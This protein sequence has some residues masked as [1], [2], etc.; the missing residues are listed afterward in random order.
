[1]F[2]RTL[3]NVAYYIYYIRILTEYVFQ[4]FFDLK[5][6]KKWCNFR[7]ISSV[8]INSLLCYE[9]STDK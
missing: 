7:I 4:G 5:C 3:F 1:M 6:C 8:C 9:T 2:L